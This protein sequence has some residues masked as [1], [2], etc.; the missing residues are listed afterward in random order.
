MNKKKTIFTGSAPAVVTPMN[1]DGVDYDAFGELIDFLIEGGSDAVVVAGTTGEAST[2]T[3]DEHVKVIES[4]V[5]RVKGRVP[6]I[7]GTGSNDTYYAAELSRHAAAAGADALLLVTPYYNKTSQAGLIKHFT[8]I[9]D[10]TALPVVLYNIPGRTNINISI[11]T[12]KE[13]A[14]HDK[15]VAVK[16]AGG[17]INYFARLL[18]EVELDVYSG[19]DGMTVPVMGLGGKGVISVAANIIP[20]AMHE[21]CMLCL[22]N[23]ILTAGKK[24]LELLPLINA[25]FLDVNPIMVKTALNLMGRHAGVLRLPLVDPSE[26]T[27]DILKK[28]LTKIGLL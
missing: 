25:L 18:A 12:F 3:D 1:A 22:A 21:I 20:K 2:L 27:L 23:D 26:N 17:D 6:V 14:Q 28:E 15:I 10:S 7:A 11:D 8:T 19:D 5:R 4:C 9:A 24:Q 16:E 13:L